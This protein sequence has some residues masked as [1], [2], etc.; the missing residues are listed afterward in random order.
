[1]IALQAHY[2][3]E[4]NATKRIDDSNLTQQP[5]STSSG[6]KEETQIYCFSFSI[7][8]SSINNNQGGK[9]NQQHQ[10]CWFLTKLIPRSFH[11][12][13]VQYICVLIKLRAMAYVHLECYVNVRYLP[14]VHK[15][16]K[17]LQQF[18]LSWLVMTAWT[19]GLGQYSVSFTVW[20]LIFS[21][22]ALCYALYPTIC[23][24][25]WWSV[26]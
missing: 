18:E 5:C 22:E 24:L 20:I 1:M 23:N 21:L 3:E 6:F 25:C 12:G 15:M 26:A 14:D 7:G 8:C 2:P 11:E 16:A 19:E 10:P 9:R 13:I 17:N 4:W